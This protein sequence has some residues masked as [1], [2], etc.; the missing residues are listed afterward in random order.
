M[1]DSG[2]LRVAAGAMMMFGSGRGRGSDMRSQR[3]GGTDRRSRCSRP[4]ISTH[5]ATMREEVPVSAD[6]L[7]V[8]P[9]RVAERPVAL[10]VAPRGTTG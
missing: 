5:P 1:V 2:A 9:R 4:S 6:G 10:V 3:C 8:C 7:V